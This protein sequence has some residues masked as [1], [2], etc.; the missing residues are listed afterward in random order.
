LTVG[1]FCTPCAA[2]DKLP[3]IYAMYD[4]DGDGTLGPQEVGPVL[5]REFDRL[6]QDGDGTL[7]ADELAQPL[8]AELTRRR[9]AK[10]PVTEPKISGETPS[11][12]DVT[13]YL[14]ETAELGQL[15]GIALR[16]QRGGELL[17]EH[18]LGDLAPDTVVPV[19]SG[20]KWITGALLMTLV[21]DGTLQ[22]DEPLSRHLEYLKGM[23][24][25][26]V[27]LRQALSHTAGFG[28][29]HLLF[30]PFDME[31]A[32]SAK[33]L[34]DTER[35]NEPG[36]TFHYTG[37]AMQFA[38]AAAE[39]AAGKSW[40]EL[41]E[42]RIAGPLGMSDT[43]YGHPMRSID[44]EPNRNQTVESGVHTTLRDYGRFLEM[45]GGRGVFRGTRVLSEA[46]V[47]E[48]ETDHT[49]GFDFSFVPP[50]AREGWGYGLG[51]W[52][53]KAD[54]KQSC[55]KMNSAGAMGA[56]PWIDRNRDISGVLLTV[57]SIPR[58]VERI[59]AIRALVEQVVD[60]NASA[61]HGS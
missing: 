4:V 11:F 31:I 32:A 18:S 26:P 20:S 37:V 57:D 28:S 8:M 10:V 56:F 22:L 43:A 42:E 25:E 35:P 39:A 52:C 58:L 59:L 49:H 30:Q 51:L 23:P 17:Y 55:T 19:A 40:T 61:A 24:A 5:R 54:A 48:M 53:E 33:A 41:F 13:A 15:A 21:D 47:A 29:E 2:D 6:D 1:I 12:A 7:S 27:T 45:I 44:F 46:S 50:G 16:V 60:D 3:A 14:E 9:A 36:T 34:A 38:A